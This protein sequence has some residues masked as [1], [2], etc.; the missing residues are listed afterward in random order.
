MMEDVDGKQHIIDPDV[1]YE[2]TAD[3]VK[4]LLATYM[5]FRYLTVD[6]VL[7]MCKHI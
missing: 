6:I 5:R 4:K 7:L 2:L 1:T 3:S